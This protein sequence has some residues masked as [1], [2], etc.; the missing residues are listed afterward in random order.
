MGLS[1]VVYWRMASRNMMSIPDFLD[2]PLCILGVDD[3]LMHPFGDALGVSAGE[4]EEDCL[5]LW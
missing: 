1:G 4:E 2:L 3:F 5:P